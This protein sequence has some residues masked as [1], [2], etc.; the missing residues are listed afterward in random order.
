MFTF[1]SHN[2]LDDSTFKIKYEPRNKH[3]IIFAQ[4]SVFVMSQPFIY[5]LMIISCGSKAQ[6][7]YDFEAETSA[8]F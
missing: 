8:E 4:I 6:V 1:M 2:V 5:R 7:K 3:L